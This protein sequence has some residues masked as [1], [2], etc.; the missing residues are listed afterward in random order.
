[1]AAAYG[2]NL[3]RKLKGTL[4]QTDPVGPYVQ[5]ATHRPTSQLGYKANRAAG[6][7][8]SQR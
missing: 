6:G 8:T 7:P 3:G 1:M 5:W 2:D 4:A